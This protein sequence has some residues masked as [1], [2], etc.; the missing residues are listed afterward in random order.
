MILKY[1]LFKYNNQEESKFLN[2]N[3]DAVLGCSYYCISNQRG[4]INVALLVSPINPHFRLAVYAK[5]GPSQST[6]IR[7]TEEAVSGSQYTPRLSY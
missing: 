5:L 3:K 1:I 6:N 4:H 7:N 2:V